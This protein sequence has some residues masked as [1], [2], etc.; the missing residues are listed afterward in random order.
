MKKI[1]FILFASF[2][3]I[4]LVSCVNNGTE[5]SHI[6][7]NKDH[8][9]DLCET[10]IGKHKDLNNDGKCDYCGELLGNWSNSA[11]QL[12]I[13][14]LRMTLPYLGA[15]WSEPEL[16]KE[17]IISSSAIGNMEELKT[18]FTEDGYEIQDEVFPY[19]DSGSNVPGFKAKKDICEEGYAVVEI[20]DF[21]T[22]D[23]GFLLT[24]YQVFNGW[25]ASL[26]GLYFENNDGTIPAVEADSYSL[27]FYKETYHVYCYGGN[28]ENYF[29][30][31]S[32]SYYIDETMKD[33][34]QPFYS[35]YF[36]ENFIHTIQ[37]AFLEYDDY[38]VVSPSE[39]SPILPRDNWDEKE[40]DLMEDVLGETLPFVNAEFVI[41]EGEL[42][43]LQT[44]TSYSLRL[45]AFEMAA[46]VFSDDDSWSEEYDSDSL[47]YTFIKTSSSDNEKVIV[48]T[49]YH[50]FGQCYFN[51]Y[52]VDTELRNWPAQAISD[53]IINDTTEV[54]P[55]WDGIL[56][57]VSYYVEKYKALIIDA[58]GDAK[59]YIA[60]L[61]NANWSIDNQINQY[62]Y[63]ECLSP[64]ETLTIAVLPQRSTFQIQILIN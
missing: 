8:K 28:L 58:V 47:L 46:K 35:M 62:N 33:F 39:V 52:C 27:E 12:M 13:K 38:F 16:N 61:E 44:F 48:V 14:K 42:N 55:S 19:K 9:C 37:I 18:L 15:T 3:T 57:V 34:T 11:Q 5:C 60:V 20:V 31:L 41:S 29:T 53:Y 22:Y 26:A 24:A 17:K 23:E 25:P 10:N 7:S 40:T 43:R 56:F 1:I 21:S 59:D 45:G 32:A 51:A 50:D 49:I 63:Y 6:D 4:N 30:S 2:L 36:A 54:V 64:N